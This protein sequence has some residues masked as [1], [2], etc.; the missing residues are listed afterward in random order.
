MR[1]NATSTNE[2]GLGAEEQ[3]NALNGVELVPD[4]GCVVDTSDRINQTIHITGDPFKIRSGN[5]IM[6]LT[7]WMIDGVIGEPMVRQQIKV[8]KNKTW[9]LHFY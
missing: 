6:I 3:R 8:A 1:R 7:L 5:S 2:N 9:E 4:D